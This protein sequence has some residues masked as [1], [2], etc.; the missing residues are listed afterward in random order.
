[1]KLTPLSREVR[2]S[3]PDVK[4]SVLP[5]HGSVCCSLVLVPSVTGAVRAQGS[6]RAWGT[7]QHMPS[8]VCD[9]K[10]GVEECAG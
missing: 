5:E 6:E 7:G 9:T 10:K 4:V 2:I 1:M 8:S 3:V